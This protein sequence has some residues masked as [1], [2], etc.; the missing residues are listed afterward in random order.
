MSRDS[1]TIR[2]L[3]LHE[4]PDEAE[5]IINALRNSGRATRATQIF[6]EEELLEE[7]KNHSWD[8]FLARPDADGLE[9]EQSLDHINRLEKD[10]P[11]VVLA[12][13]NSSDSVVSGLKAG[14]QDVVPCHETERLLLVINREL[15]NLYERRQRRQ[16]DISLRETERRCNL[17]LDSS[18]DA[19]TYVIDGMHIYAN[20]S[21]LEMFAYEEADELEGMPILDMVSSRDH[22]P[23]KAFMKKFNSNNQG[24]AEF[25]CVGIRTDGS[26]INTR[27]TFSAA[28]Y[29]GEPCIQIVIR[30]D[31]DDAELQE[32]L[33]EISSQDLL[34][35]LFNRQYFLQQMDSHVETALN[36]EKHYGLL[37]IGIDRYQQ[38]KSTFGI[39]GAD[40]VLG[41]IATLLKQA[42]GEDSVLARFSE[43]DFTCLTGESNIDG[44]LELA[45]KIRKQI[46]EHMSEVQGQTVQVTASIGVASVNES[47]PGSQEIIDRA[48]QASDKVRDRDNPG[49]GVLSFHPPAAAVPDDLSIGEQLQKAIDRGQ[50]KIL[51]QPIIS[52]RGD[53]QEFYEVLLRMLDEDGEEI[54]PNDFLESASQSRLAEKID[55]WVIVQSLKTLAAHRAQGHDTRLVINLTSESIRDKT[56][57][58]WLSVAIKAARIPSDCLIFQLSENDSTTYLKQAIAFTKGLKELHFRC[59]ISRFGGAINPFNALKHLDVDYL[60][61]DGS[62]TQE[63]DNEE[64]RERLK[65]LVT[66]AHSHEKMTIAPYVESAGVLSTLWQ[67]GISY[68]QGYYL[69][70]PMDNMDYDFSSEE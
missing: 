31:V 58:S 10:I 22:E 44:A 36:E 50:F 67:I 21:Y 26:E 34:T 55:R 47:C 59:C 5:Q 33:K 38:V 57:L 49:N 28:S 25:Q 65:E 16:T 60:K 29:D 48:H 9:V 30:N 1:K 27:M 69:A 51:F 17:L 41:D 63:I 56:L 19:I 62:F 11:T 12:D 61:I 14:A 54:S 18:R 66:Q 40:L 32:K 39:A 20:E 43:S 64:S 35:G 68:I 13:E 3:V 7:L 52:L 4:S 42:A 45:E 23:F 46:E 8:L 15:N 53:N 37:Y 2:V 6:S 24:E 70:P